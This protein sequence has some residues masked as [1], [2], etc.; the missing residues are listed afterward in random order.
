MKIIEWNCQGAF[1]TKNEKILELKP[2]LLII[3]ECENEEKLN[4]GKDTPQPND[5]YWY[6]KGKKGIGIFSYSDYKIKPLPLFNS[7][8]NYII[9]LLVY[10]QSNSFL[11]FAI[12][13]MDDKEN[14]SK[15]YIGQIWLAINFYKEI[16]NDQVLL[17]GD[18]NSNQ[19]WD[20]KSRIG[21]HTAMV[22]L[23]SS[24]HI[25]SLYHKQEN[26]KHGAE[27]D[28]TFFMHRNLEKKYHI[29]YIFSS[30][31]IIKN[32][33]KLTLGNSKD[34]ITLSDHIPLIL[35]MNPSP[36]E[37]KFNYSLKE[38]I[39]TK[40]N[41]LNDI[42]QIKYKT[43]IAEII[44]SIEDHLSKESIDNIYRKYEL[45]KRIEELT[46]KL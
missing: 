11:I 34:W 33:F 42:I 20:E 29:D 6:S 40:F 2:D 35:E 25:E 32:G 39:L 5:F 38:F 8:F 31:N 15:R 9:P 22:N 45:L 41:L 28:F 12:W 16:F 4:F 1:R 24:Y 17:I 46:L 18:F 37:N 30:L 26:L 23:L 36:S 27:T 19:R 7:N 3:L 44:A 43:E 21:N 13:A 14:P 10:N